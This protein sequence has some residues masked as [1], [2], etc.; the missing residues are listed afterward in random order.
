MPSSVEWPKT[1]PARTLP[2]HSRSLLSQHIHASSGGS[3]AATME[4]TILVVG[5]LP[6][7]AFGCRG[8][9]S[10]EELTHLVNRLGEHVRLLFPGIDGHLGFWCQLY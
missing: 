5:H 7:S 9:M 3:L 6:V 8:L 10:S 1:R 4:M 2:S